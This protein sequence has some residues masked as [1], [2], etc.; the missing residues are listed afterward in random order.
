MRDYL[1]KSCLLASSAVGLASPAL[2]QQT[3]AI[4]NTPGR[5]QSERNWAEK[6]FSDM[7][8][9]MGTVAK[10]TTVQKTLTITNLYKEDITVSGL[11]TSCGCFHAKT[12]KKT[13]KTH[14]VA[15]ITVDMNTIKFQGERHANLNVTLQFQ[16]AYKSVQV[17]LH[18]FIRTDVTIEPGFLNLGTVE[19][20]QGASKS[21]TVKFSGRQGMKV[22][23]VRSNNPLIKTEVKHRNGGF[24]SES[25]VVVTLD[26][27]APLGAVRDLLT[28]VTSDG[29][30]STMQVDVAGKV[31]PDLVLTP[32]VLSLGKLRPGVEK[33]YS[34]V[35]RGHRPFAIEKLER[36][37]PVNCWVS[38]YS[39]EARSVHPIMMTIKPP[40]T[41]G[42]YEETFTLSIPGRKDPISFTARGTILGVE[43]ESSSDSDVD[44]VSADKPVLP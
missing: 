1:L 11:A 13:L 30:N 27:S 34:V 16:S 35:L 39:K 40:E 5:S 23:E 9:E 21:V 19:Q 6:M 44:Q 37:S 3:A 26:P 22:K 12:D 7:R 33:T 42:P 41:A 15:T 17:P 31:E 24:G 4:V 10:G 36:D 29:N 32:T 28:I 18:G 2:A 43:G 25:D 20:G 38:K 8:L 14:E